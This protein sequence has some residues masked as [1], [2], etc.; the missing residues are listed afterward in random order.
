MKKNTELN[1]SVVSMRRRAVCSLND[2]DGN[3]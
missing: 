3:S 2:E 1:A